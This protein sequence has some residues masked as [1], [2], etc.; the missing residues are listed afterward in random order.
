MKQRL[1]P[2]I[3]LLLREGCRRRLKNYVMACIIGMDTII[4]DKFV[5]IIEYKQ[6]KD[7]NDFRIIPSCQITDSVIQPPTALKS[8]VS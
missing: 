7:L 3:F 2:G 1:F 5:G 8:Q 4:S 6:I